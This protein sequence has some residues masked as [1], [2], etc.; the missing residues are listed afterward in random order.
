M[1]KT[2]Q[3]AKKAGGSKGLSLKKM[4]YENGQKNVK[5]YNIIFVTINIRRIV[6]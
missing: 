4:N 2:P 1:F 6:R 5:M 3:Q